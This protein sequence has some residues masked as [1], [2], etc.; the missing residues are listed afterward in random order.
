[1]AEMN[2]LTRL[3][4]E[5]SLARHAGDRSYA[6]GVAYFEQGAVVDLVQTREGLK[7]RVQ[8]S[9][10]YRVTLRAV[11]RRLD[12]D[13]TCP[14]GEDGEFCKHAVAA[15][16][17]WL[18]QRAGQASAGGLAV[19]GDELTQIRA[20]LGGQS[21]EALIEH[22][23]DQAAE[24]LELRARLH[25]EA[26]R[27]S[28]PVDLKAQK[29]IVRRALAVPGGF[30][31]SQ[32]MRA[33]VARA[34]SVVELLRGLIDAGQA[35]NA[36]ELA[37]Y[38]MHRGIAA[39]EHTDDSSGA[40]GDTL[41]GLAEL[42]L[43]ACRAAPADPEALGAALFKLQ[44]ID[45]WGYFDL[46]DYAPLLGSKGLARYRALVQTA[47]RELPPARPGDRSEYSGRAFRLGR[48]MEALARH[49]QDIDALVAIKA[50]D[51]TH[52]YT[53]VQIANILADAKRHD[54][55]LAWA[56]RGRKAF[57]RESDPRLIEFLIA[58]YRRAHRNDEAIAVAWQH[59]T[60][61][62]SLEAYKLLRSACGA[63]AWAEWR[64]KA[65]AHIRLVLQGGQRRAAF[66][67]GGHSLLVEIFLD[68]GDSSAALAEAKAG[69]CNEALWMAIA[70]ARES[71][72]PHDAIV[73]YLA[74]VDPIVQRANNRAYDDAARLMKKVGGLMQRTG[75]SKAFEAWLAGLRAKHKAKRNFL[76]RVEGL[77]DRGKG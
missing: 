67:W 28:A 32:R 8:G 46:E 3:I 53:Y 4:T 37:D 45:G 19:A 16:L 75:E 61:R 56:E 15:G 73:I 9:D 72:H 58:A 52:A 6:R 31:D 30:V 10:E 69:G 51:L 43:Q 71:E 63:K 13:C 50:R 24:D 60:Q 1:M 26:L 76:Q 47:W 17:A 11:G 74:R 20:Y 12:A 2:P 54:D 66:Q 70:A 65:I 44:M 41:H 7:A 23:M 64:D 25:A 34:E 27:A 29:E 55:A 48:L 33:L 40:F 42:H 68:E 59:F 5:S 39:Y 77:I 49:A 21:K 57:P 38:A 36:L 22:L 62:S 35:R 14:M 18:A